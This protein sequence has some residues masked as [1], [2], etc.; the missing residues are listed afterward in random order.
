MP[1]PA[2]PKTYLVIG[3]AGFIGGHVV[4]MLLAKGQHVV[5]ID[6]HTDQPASDARDGLTVIRA[7][8]RTAPLDELFREHNIAGVF[9]FAAIA[10]VPYS[11]EHPDEAYEVNVAASMRLFEACRQHGVKR[12]IFSSSSAIYGNG[13]DQACV[14]TQPTNPLSPYALHKLVMEQFLTLYH[15]LYGL[16]T[17]SLRYFNVFGPRQNGEGPY[18]PLIPKC[19]ANMRAGEAITINGSGEQTRDLVAVSDVVEAN[20][21]AA[22]TTN[23]ACFGEAFNI[24][25]GKGY[26]VNE[27][28]TTLAEAIGGPAPIH[29]AE[30]VEVKNSLA[31][32]SKAR[33]LLGWEPRG[34]FKEKIKELI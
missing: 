1:N 12:F 23:A 6:N 13:S 19:L 28:V 29:G 2:S 9:H 14:E 24:G 18:A 21:L 32:I 25:S 8:L 30:V 3:A 4:D 33:T 16:E 34:D 17:V 20:W 26:S 7:D 27:I 22:T 31:D 10:S 15:Q 5:A 11:I